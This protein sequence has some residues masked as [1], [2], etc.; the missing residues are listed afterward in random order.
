VAQPDLDRNDYRALA[1]FRFLI[2]SFL[3]FSES[4]AREEGL[5]LQ[6]HQMLLAI[7]AWEGDDSP[8]IGQLAEQ[9]LI[10]HHSA[11]GLADRLEQHR[12]IERVRHDGDRRQVH[13]RLTPAGQSIL[14]RL[15]Q[16]HYA[17]LRD[18][19]PGL[20]D[21]LSELLQGVAAR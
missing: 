2:R 4:A 20:V 7:R 19:G 10:R 1:R 5:E 8:T 16:A 15:S 9:L 21:A 3:Q 11:V 14:R 12:L 18:Q 6:Q 17:E 13:L